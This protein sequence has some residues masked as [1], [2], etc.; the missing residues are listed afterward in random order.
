MPDRTCSMP[1]CLAPENARKLCKS[2]YRRWSVYGDPLGM[3]PPKVA[4]ICDEPGCGKKHF[5]KGLCATH[6]SAAYYRENLAATKATQAVYRQAHRESDRARVRAWREANLERARAGNRDYARRHAAALLVKRRHYRAA[7]R[8]L[9]RTLNNR[10]KALKR[11]APVNDLTTA[12]WRD[13]KA[14]YGQRC[15]YCKK[16][17]FLTMDH[18]IPLSKGGSHTASNIVPACGS[19]NSKKC[20]RPAP[21]HQPLLF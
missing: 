17:R 18:V 11:N 6:Y 15:A 14:A 5:G 7:N 10:H 1:D 12:Q 16:R 20:N 9:I 4:R 3:P 21:Q 13:I 19:C 2:H 8:D